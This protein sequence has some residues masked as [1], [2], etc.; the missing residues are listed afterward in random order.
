[1]MKPAVKVLLIVLAVLFAAAVFLLGFR[2]GVLS[3]LREVDRANRENAAS[4]QYP[5]RHY[6]AAVLLTD[7]GFVLSD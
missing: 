7:G 5:Y 6:P 1:M 2:A 3:K 4:L